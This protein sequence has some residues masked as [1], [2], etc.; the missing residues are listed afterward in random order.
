MWQQGRLTVNHKMEALD[1][2]FFP[3]GGREEMEM[4]WI[5]VGGETRVHVLIALRTELI[6]GIKCLS[7]DGYLNLS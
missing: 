2:L 1:V 6:K 7:T 3:S 4:G 5:R